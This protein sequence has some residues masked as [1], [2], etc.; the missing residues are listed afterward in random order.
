MF[1]VLEGELLYSTG[2]RWAL[3]GLLDRFGV[4]LGVFGEGFGR[5]LGGLLGASFACCGLL[6]LAL[7][8]LAACAFRSIAT[9]VLLYSGLCWPIFRS[10]GGLVVH[11]CDFFA[12]L[13][14]SCLFLTIFW[15]FGSIFGGFGRVSGRF[16]ESFF[17]VFS[18]FYRKC[19]LC[20]NML[21]TH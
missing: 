14:L 5:V 7:A 11:F 6:W 8:A 16:W 19:R 20:K 3:R 10:W 4:D 12:H 17:K 9:Q 18:H 15:D 2:P 1:G 13:N 21:P